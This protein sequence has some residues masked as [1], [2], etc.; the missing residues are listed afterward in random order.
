[1]AARG[2]A[3]MISHPSTTGAYRQLASGGRIA[4]RRPRE[5]PGREAGAGISL[6]AFSLG[7][8]LQNEGYLQVHLVADDVAV[9][10]QHVLVF[11]PGTLDTP[12]GG[13]GAA[14]GLLDGI[15]EACL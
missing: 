7:T 2:A 6:S 3:A 12:K 15:L 11:D 14:Y 4:T 5:N 13:G 9:L 1:M 8:A 10:D